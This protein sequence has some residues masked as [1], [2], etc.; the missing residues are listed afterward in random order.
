[1]FLRKVVQ[2]LRDQ[3]WTAIGIDLLI[4]IVG[5]FIGAQAS[6]WNEERKERA[7][8][9]VFLERLHEDLATDLAVLRQKDAYLT[10]AAE[11]GRRAEGFIAAGRPCESNCWRVL[12]DFFAASQFQD[13]T[14]SRGVLQTLQG[15]PYPYDQALKRE[16]I[17]FYSV[18]DQTRPVMGPSEYRRRMRLHVPMKVLVALW[19]CNTT[20]GE[21]QRFD[22]A[23]PPGAPEAELRPVLERIRAD[24]DL[25]AELATDVGMRATLADLIADVDARA[26]R[27]LGRIEAKIGKR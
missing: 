9:R 24:A 25:R 16:I 10:A 12:L 3:N 20:L 11:A 22:F 19:R 18:I 23:C 6:N 15:S 27:A 17:G 8:E 26:R 13:V 1:M 21:T 14:S 5:V 4:V 2:H 7:G